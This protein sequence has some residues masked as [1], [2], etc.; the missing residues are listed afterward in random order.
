MKDQKQLS[1]LITILSGVRCMTQKVSVFLA[2]FAL[3]LALSS[4]YTTRVLGAQSG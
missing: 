1:K 4:R 2:L 3:T